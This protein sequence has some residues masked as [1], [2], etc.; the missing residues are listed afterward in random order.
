M[1][2]VKAM[3]FREFE[4]SSSALDQARALGM[5]GDVPGRLKRMAQQSAPFTHPDGNRRYESY[6]L[7]VAGGVVEA[8]YKFTGQRVGDRRAV[9][10]DIPQAPRQAHTGAMV[11]CPDC[12][13]DGGVCLTCNSTGKVRETT[14]QALAG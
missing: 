7:K 6:I 10:A 3:A 5:F 1:G 4:V 8:I 12:H 14:L 11:E 13:G 2:Q 9:R